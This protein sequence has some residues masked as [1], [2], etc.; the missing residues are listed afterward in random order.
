[1]ILGL[2]STAYAGTAL[3]VVTPGFERA[4]FLPLQRALVR[5]GQGVVWVDGP[6]PASVADAVGLIAEATRAH[7]DATVVAHG[8]GA[9]FALMAAKEAPAA[10]YVLLAPVLGVVPSPLMQDLAASPAPPS[11][12]LAVGGRW[13]DRDVLDVLLGPVTPEL[14]VLSGTLVAELQ[15]WVRAG[16]VPVDLSAVQAPVWLEIGLTDEVA[17]VEAVVPASRLLPHR[18]LVRPGM[19]RFNPQDFTHGEIL[20][21]PIPTRLAARA[22]RSVRW[23][24]RLAREA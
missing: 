13:R 14:N 8:V 1:M 15:G 7:P 10:R 2:L 11:V 17:T 16:R 4:A 19:T 22:V 21:H 12:D 9:T 5:E 24:R 3:L 20:T 23:S 18:R 6:P